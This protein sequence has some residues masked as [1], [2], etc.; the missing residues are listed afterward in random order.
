MGR[1]RF[2]TVLILARFVYF[3]IKLLNRSSGT[4]FVGMLVLKICPNFIKYC[5]DYVGLGNIITVTGTN[6]KT[7]TSGLLAHI[8]KCAGNSVI[9]N[10]KGANMLTGIANMFAL[11]IRPFKK[12]NFAVIESDEAYL[13]KLYDY[14]EADSL[15]VTNLFRD[16]LD[17]Y[18]ELET[19]AGFIK[20]AID[21][22]PDLMVFLNA[23]DPLVTNLD[24]HGIFY[25]FEEVEIRSDEHKTVSSAPTEVFNCICGKPLSYSKQ[26]FAQQGHYY[27]EHCGYKRPELDYKGYVK[28]YSDH[29]D[30][31]VVDVDKNKEYTFRVNQVGLYNAYNALAAVSCALL[32]CCD[33]EDVIRDALNSYKSIFGR[34]ERRVINGHDTLIQL[35]KNPTG[36]SEVLKTVDLESNIVIAINDNYADGR[37]ISWLWDSDFEQLKNAKKLVITSGIRAKDMAL[38]LKY[39]GIAQDKIIIEEDIK[40]A[41][42]L[43]VSSE[44]KNE[45]VTI[46]PSY[47]ALLKINK[48]KF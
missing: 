11:G 4:S 46:L 18:G 37:D 48:M 41:I 2:Y 16:Q 7:T 31:I 27:C 10:T 40:S 43:A 5:E 21:K 29:S 25:G 6:G 1:V 19:T 12:F 32:T 24:K 35:I 26:F 38:R 17:R 28:I 15:L 30:L 34:A 44:D 47:T 42:E 8:V 9:H 45:K 22:N 20:D 14:M 13:T 39:A 3:G 33:N 23:D 36:A